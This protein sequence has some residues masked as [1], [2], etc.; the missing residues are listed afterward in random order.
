M[1][2]RGR[3]A[4]AAP[5]PGW[6]GAG[7][8]RMPPYQQPEPTTFVTPG[9]PPTEGVSITLANLLPEVL[10]NY[11]SAKT[12]FRPRQARKPPSEEKKT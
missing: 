2:G 12:L 1:V 10:L 11:A 7:N 8:E 4:N 3:G 6:P 9:Q 5:G